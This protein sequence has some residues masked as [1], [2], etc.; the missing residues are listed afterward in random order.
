[1]FK[2]VVFTAIC[3]AL[4]SGCALLDPSDV[5]VEKENPAPPAS[6]SQPEPATSQSAAAAPLTETRSASEE[7]NNVNPDY[8]KRIQIHLK[9]TGFYSGA[10]DGVA[11][12]L[13]QSAIRHFQSGCVTLKD[14]LTISD[15]AAIQQGSAMAAKAAITQSNR[16]SDKAVRLI[17]LRLK[18]AGFD[19]G[20]IDGIYGAKTAGARLT[21]NSGCAMLQEFSPVSAPGNTASVNREGSATIISKDP[22]GKLLDPTNREA[23]RS[24]QMRLQ[25][26]GFDPGPIDGILG[27]K[28][29]TA[30]QRYQ[31]SVAEVSASPPVGE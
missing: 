10:V 3:I 27:P 20:P 28:T 1:M 16:S 17:Q 14:L 25:N 26:A 8:V 23:V 13:T 19:P 2:E 15:H 4:I 29:R 5:E 30:L 24:L 11:G 22:D 12:P 6:D 21:L 7:S 18:D 31:A 9:R